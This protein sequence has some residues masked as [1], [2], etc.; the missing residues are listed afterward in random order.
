MAQVLPATGSIIR[1][2]GQPHCKRNCRFTLF[3]TFHFRHRAYGALLL[4]RTRIR[5]GT[6]LPLTLAP[7]QLN[8]RALIA[9][10]MLAAFVLPVTA[11]AACYEATAPSRVAVQ[12][13]IKTDA[14][15]TTATEAPAPTPVAAGE[16][17]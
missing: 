15:A 16:A 2:R 12:M 6:L 7:F 4:N 3:Q 14:A 10:V 1:G 11:K 17:K 5:F 13:I 8:W 9:F